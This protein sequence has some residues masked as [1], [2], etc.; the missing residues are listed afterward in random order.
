ML[1]GPPGLSGSVLC[2]EPFLLHSAYSIA[3]F[4]IHYYYYYY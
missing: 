1:A 2:D 3:V 4:A